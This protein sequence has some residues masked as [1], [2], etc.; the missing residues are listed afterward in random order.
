[1]KLARC[2]G[3]SPLR[4]EIQLPHGHER[5]ARFCHVPDFRGDDRRQVE[6]PRQ[7]VVEI[8]SVHADDALSP[9]QRVEAMG[10]ET[11]LTHHEP[12]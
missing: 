1:M 7:G 6:S 12:A 2:R 9:T 5:H 3:F 4:R 8:K 10:C 11:A